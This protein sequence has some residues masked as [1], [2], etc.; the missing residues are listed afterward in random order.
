MDKRKNVTLRS[1]FLDGFLVKN[2]NETGT[3]NIIVVYD[4]P[5]WKHDCFFLEIVTIR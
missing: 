3:T 4:F 2:F 1:L 5:I